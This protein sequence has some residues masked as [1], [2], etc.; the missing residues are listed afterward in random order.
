MFI[1]F[2]AVLIG[3]VISISFLSCKKNLAE[4]KVQTAPLFETK[5]ANLIPFT[6]EVNENVGGYYMGIPVRYDSTDKLYPL[7]LFIPGAGQFGNGG[8]DLPKLLKEGPIQLLE[9]KIFPPN[10]KVNDQNFSFLIAA[11]Q[12]RNYPGT[13]HLKSFIDDIKK[14]YRVDTTRIY[15]AGLSIGGR[16]TCDFAA[17]Y[18]TELAAIVPMAGV[19]SNSTDLAEKT[20]KIAAANLPVW[21]FHNED[22]FIF[23]I[24]EP[25]TFVSKLNSFLPQTRAK[26]TTWPT[27]GHDAWSKASDPKFTENNLNIYE[28]MLQYKRL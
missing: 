20:R 8:I 17:E 24:S 27:G 23:K 11:P 14:R 4:I 9:E 26:L 2:K 22:D 7:L 18:P 1:S 19:S 10:F 13:G 28:W 15:I 6:R 5:P 12:F 25:I 21:V 3:G 16:M